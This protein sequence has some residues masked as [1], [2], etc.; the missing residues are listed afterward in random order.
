MI[1]KKYG[2]GKSTVGDIKK[3]KEKMI[4]FVSTPERGTGTR[5]ILKNPENPILEKTLFIWFM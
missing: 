5:K 4:K 3:N 1:A 2:I